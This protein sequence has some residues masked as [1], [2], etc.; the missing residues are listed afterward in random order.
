MS[1]SCPAVARTGGE[2]RVPRRLA[3]AGEAY[4]GGE[5]FHV[6]GVATDEVIAGFTFHAHPYLV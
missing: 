6:F 2:A 3:I 1:W 4:R 5:R